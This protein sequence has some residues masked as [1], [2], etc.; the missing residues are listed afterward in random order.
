MKFYII[1]L[2]VFCPFLILVANR[3][4]H[5]LQYLSRS[6]TLYG[7]FDND[8]QKD[9]IVKS[10]FEAEIKYDIYLKRNNKFEKQLS[11]ILVPTFFSNEDFFKNADL[12]NDTK[13]SISVVGFCCGNWKT[14]ETFFYTYND[15]VKTWI[16]SEKYIYSYN[17]DYTINYEV[18]YPAIAI[19]IDGIKF[20]TIKTQDSIERKNYFNKLL[21]DLL[22]KF[23][24]AHEKKSAYPTLKLYPKYIILDMLTA[25]PITTENLIKYNDLAY[26]FQQTTTEDVN[27]QYILEDL[28]KKFPLRTAAYINLGDAYWDSANF[29]KAK[30]AYKKY[31]TLMKVDGKESKIPQLVLTRMKS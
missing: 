23:S 7:Y 13:G 20:N 15:E 30:E 9:F 29:S 25:V 18:E 28:V 11:N 6:D 2:L 12:Y 5:V 14:V 27:A 31:V 3:N 17:Q 4:T 19:S 10:F 16:L 26:Y 24:S 8:N 22:L 21:S 1:S